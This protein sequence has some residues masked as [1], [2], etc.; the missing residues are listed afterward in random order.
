M[1]PFLTCRQISDFLGDYFDGTL[2]GEARREFDRHLAVCPSCVRYLEGYKSTLK[3]ARQA[4]R[5][6]DD[7]GGAGAA[8]PPAGAPAATVPEELIQAIL[9]A[10]R[11]RGVPP[12][13]GA[14][15]PSE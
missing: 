12:V 13:A 7:A 6:A 9:A 14:G 3:E 1:D 15:S 5:A 10:R 11:S 2:A 4:H 8:T